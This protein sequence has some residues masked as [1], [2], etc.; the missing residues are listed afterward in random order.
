MPAVTKQDL[1]AAFRDVELCDLLES[2]GLCPTILRSMLEKLFLRS[3][4]NR[5]NRESLIEE[6]KMRGIKN[7]TRISKEVLCMQLWNYNDY[8]DST[9]IKRIRTCN[10]KE[11]KHEDTPLQKVKR[12]KVIAP[13]ESL[14]AEGERL[15]AMRYAHTNAK[16]NMKEEEP[17]KP[18]VHVPKK[19]VHVIPSEQNPKH[20]KELCVPDD[21]EK[22]P[23]CDKPYEEKKCSKKHMYCMTNRK[24]TEDRVPNCVYNSYYDAHIPISEQKS[25]VDDLKVEHKREKRISA[26]L[27]IRL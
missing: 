25:T 14:H 3:L 4:V 24:Y 8:T 20:E 6:A 11:I 19:V 13:E 10:K 9:N 7:Y 17:E 2:K 22:C 15:F 1:S 18:S 16:I 23:L 21:N 12:P 27:Q 5:L 26:W